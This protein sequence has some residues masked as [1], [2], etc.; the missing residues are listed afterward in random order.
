MGQLI[1]YWYLFH[2]H[3]K[4]HFNTYAD[5]FYSKSTK[6]ACAD[7][8]TTITLDDGIVKHKR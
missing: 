8:Y 6:L 1:R 7:S 4:P 2:M 5:V 3:K